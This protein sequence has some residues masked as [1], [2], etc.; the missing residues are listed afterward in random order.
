MNGRVRVSVVATGIDGAQFREAEKPK[1]VAMGGGAAQPVNAV[2]N[3][4]I[5]AAPAGGPGLPFMRRAAQ[6]APAMRPAIVE[7][8]L[9]VEPEAVAEPPVMLAPASAPLPEAPQLRVPVS[10]PVEPQVAPEAPRPAGLR[11]LFGKV[12]GMGGMMKR[13]LPPQAEPQSFAHESVPTA[14]M[15]PMAAPAPRV[16]T[17]R[18]AQQDEMSLEIPAFLRR[19]R[20]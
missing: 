18:P 9:A 19:Q 5:G 16:E 14:R 13:T 1:L 4:T 17:T 12:T 20:S 2:A 3:Q 15:E 8:A 11:G 6:A 7:T 10:E